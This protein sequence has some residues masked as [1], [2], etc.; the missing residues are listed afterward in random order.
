M[1]LHHFV[2]A[3]MAG[4]IVANGVFLAVGCDLDDLSGW[5]M[6]PRGPR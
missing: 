2:V 1:T 5:P 3:V 4:G 6:P